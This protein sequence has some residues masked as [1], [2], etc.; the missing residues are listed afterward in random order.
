VIAI[1]GT[2]VLSFEKRHCP[3]CLT[4]T[5]DGVTRYYHP[6]LE[7]KLVTRAGL[8]LSL[9]TEFIENVDPGANKQD[10]ELKAFYRLAVRLK[11]RFPR[12]PISVSADSLY[13]KG[14]VFALCQ[15]FGWR[16]MLVLKEGIPFLSREFEALRPLQPEN[17]LRYRPDRQVSQD[18]CWVNDTDYQDDDTG[19]S[20]PTPATGLQPK[21]STCSCSWLIWWPS[22]SSTVAFY[23]ITS[24]TVSPPPRTSP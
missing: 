8:V 21:S 19:W 10:C 11:R 12:L 24:R 18:F 16:F 14:P 5:R 2:G 3:H 1:D 17:R 6:V 23:G 22:C 15:R 7:A 20:T 9:M 4:Q 13:A